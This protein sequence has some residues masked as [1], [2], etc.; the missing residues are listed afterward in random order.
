MGDTEPGAVVLLGAGGAGSAVADALLR[1]G[2]RRLD[3]VDVDLA[4]AE[5]LAS[6][7]TTRHAAPVRAHGTDAIADLL[8]R[9][10]GLAHCTPTGMREHPGLPVAPATLRP[11]LWV[12][13]I[14]YRPLD[15]ELL[16]T[17]RDRGC[18]T[19]SGGGM[20]VHQAVDAFELITGIRPDP[21]RMHQDFAR[22]VD[23]TGEV[24]ERRLAQPATS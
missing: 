18:R 24:S 21:V 2:S 9:A 8:A 6:E 23:A 19:I 5:H 4:R 15:T 14:V 3:I 16:R 17:A 7:L 22:L 20:A 1:L 13:D 12:A 11:E 10:D